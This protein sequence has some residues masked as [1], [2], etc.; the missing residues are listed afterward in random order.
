MRGRLLLLLPLAVVLGLGALFGA[1]LLADRDASDVP[2]A[3]VGRP[4]PAIAMP[5]LKDAAFPERIEGPALVNVF[6]SWCA[7]CRE[8]HPV[9]TAIA[10]E[11]PVY[12]IAY[13][14]EPDA[15][16][17]FLQELGDPY[18]AV[19]VDRDGRAGIEWGVTGVP[20]TFLVDAQGIV[21]HRARGPL[22]AERYNALLAALAR[23]EAP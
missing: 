18:T 19:G 17:R 12:G 14:D 9:L 11:V 2:S 22:D 10:R 7:P 3:L 5:A 16:R 20:E 4:M 13:K 1:M 6:A 8:E 15:S 21:R 23:L